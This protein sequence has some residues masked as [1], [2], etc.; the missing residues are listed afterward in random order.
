MTARYAP[1][2][3]GAVVYRMVKQPGPYWPEDARMPTAAMLQPTLEDVAEGVKSGRGPGVSVFDASDFDRDVACWVRSDR[4]YEERDRWVSCATCVD[5]LRAIS[6]FGRPLQVVRD[7]LAA[8]D[9]VAPPALSETTI[10]AV[11]GGHALIEGIDAPPPRIKGEAG[12]DRA[13]KKKSYEDALH[14]VLATFRAR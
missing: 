5:E 2:A 10:A 14:L 3:A 9:R 4:A 11:R 8:D 7:P 13:A 6:P 1:L 12:S